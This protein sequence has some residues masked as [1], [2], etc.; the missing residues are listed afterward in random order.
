MRSFKHS[1]KIDDS[2]L[3]IL[4]VFA[5]RY[6][7]GRMST[8]PSIV[9]GL[10]RRFAEFLSPEQRGQICRDIAKAID[11]GHAGHQCDVAVWQDIH[12]YLRRK[13]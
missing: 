11:A 9:S 3:S 12:D 8:A 4:L 5:F 10:L 13:R 2:D 1:T 6:A 7:L